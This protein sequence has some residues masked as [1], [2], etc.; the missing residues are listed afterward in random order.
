MKAGQT[1]DSG[2]D[3]FEAVFVYEK[4]GNEQTFDL[5]HLPDST[6][7][8]VRTET[9]ASSGQ[10]SDGLIDLSFYNESGEYMDG[11]A[12]DGKVMVVSVYDTKISSH[13]W[14]EILG[15]MTDAETAAMAKET[16][17]SPAAVQEAPLPGS[18]LYLRL[19]SDSA[20][21]MVQPVL[22]QSPGSAG[23]VLYIESTG[24]KLR[25]PKELCVSPTRSLIDAL[26]SM[27]GAKNVV[28]K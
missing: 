10:E 4:D 19:P 18:T 21:Q 20:I 27:L 16:G 14:E 22:R 7:N 9:A 1:A 3:M 24:N 12:V 23:V 17:V 5:N 13:R 6:W 11:L 8:F 25:A 15:F 28:L 2:E 26:V